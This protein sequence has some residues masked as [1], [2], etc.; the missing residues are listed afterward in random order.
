MDWKTRVMIISIAG[1]ALAGFVAGTLYVRQVEA[2]GGPPRKV[3]PTTALSIGLAALAV[4]R[5]VAALGE[6][7]EEE[8]KK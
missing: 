2:Y 3:N 1:G 6:P 4:I 5:Q 8:R 7:D